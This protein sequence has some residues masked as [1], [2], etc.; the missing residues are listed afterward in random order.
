M[1]TLSMVLDTGA[2]YTMIP[3]EAAK[4]LGCD[5]AIT[6]RK[7]EIVTASSIE[8]R[9]VVTIPLVKAFGLE[10]RNLDV[11]CHDLPPH[12]PCDGLL[13]LNF[14]R[15]FNFMFY[16]PKNHYEVTP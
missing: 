14:L 13:G 4:A 2:T 16:F 10:V 12:A 9:P 5:P 7:I 15:N 6:K 11:A 3:F 1:K 8:Y